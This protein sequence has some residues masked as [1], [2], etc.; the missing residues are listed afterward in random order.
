MAQNTYSHA[1]TI[2]TTA[3]R[4]IQ[5]LARTKS[6]WVTVA[7]LIVSIVGMIGFFSWQANKD[8]EEPAVSLA[9][10]GVPEAG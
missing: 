1:E 4:E 5:V 6:I 3:G 10:V 9:V 8:S 7:I 2:T